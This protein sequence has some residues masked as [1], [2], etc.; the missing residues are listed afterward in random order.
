MGFEGSGWEASGLGKEGFH[1][2]CVRGGKKMWTARPMDIEFQDLHKQP[3]H[4]CCYIQ[5][6]EGMSCKECDIRPMRSESQ[7][8]H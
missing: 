5:L 7:G 2:Q 4:A 8:T 6:Q 1:I 3:N